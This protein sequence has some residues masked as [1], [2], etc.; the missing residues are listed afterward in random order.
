MSS[1]TTI[2]RNKAQKISTKI[3]SVKEELIEQISRT[4]IQKYSNQVNDNLF[5]WRH[6]LIEIYALSVTEDLEVS[7]NTLK[8]WGTNAVNL[9]VDL[10]LPIEIALEEVRIN[11]DTIGTIIKDEAENFNLSLDDFYAILSRFN[12]VVDRAIHWLSVS[13]SRQY[14]TRI[15]AAEATALELSIPLIK[16]TDEIGVLPLVGD[17]DTKRAQ[18]LMNKALNKGTEYDLSFLIIDLS[19]VPIIDTMVADRIFKVVNALKLTGIETVL[20]GLRPEIAQT[21]VQ[22]GIDMK[23]IPTF[24]SLHHAMKDLQNNILNP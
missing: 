17:I 16:V 19:G 11:R 3:L 8:E 20:T 14:Y 10:D 5:E 15:N 13:Y 7:F 4:N 18:E 22:L 6:N 24:S 9:L 21:M 12:F 1:Y 23:D 2:D